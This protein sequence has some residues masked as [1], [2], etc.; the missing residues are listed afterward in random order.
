M[1][2]EYE[3]MAD[4]SKNKGLKTENGD[5]A[6]QEGSNWPHTSFREA[7]TYSGKTLLN[8]YVFLLKTSL[9]CSCSHLPHHLPD[10]GSPS[11]GRSEY[12]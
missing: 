12:S 11:Q 6:S 3:E 1:R 4:A 2:A 8:T 5:Q 10:P 7:S 9:T